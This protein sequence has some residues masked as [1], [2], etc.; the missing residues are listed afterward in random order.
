MA[1]LVHDAVQ[2]DEQDNVSSITLPFTATSGASGLVAA[3]GCRGAPETHDTVK[4][5][6]NT[7][8]FTKHVDHPYSVLRTS[9]WVLENPTIKSDNVVLT[10]G[11]SQPTVAMAVFSVS[12]LKVTDPV[13]DT[14]TDDGT[15][16][17]VSVDLTAETDDLCVDSLFKGGGAGATQGGG[18]TVLWSLTGIGP[19]GYIC[20]F[21]G[22]KEDG[23]ASVTMSW[24]FDA[25][26]H[27][28]AAMVLQHSRGGGQAIWFMIE[29]LRKFYEDLKRG[30]ISQDQ[31][32]RRYR[33]GCAI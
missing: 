10:L 9:L 20:G 11:G 3:C 8:D 7:E 25:I 4:W 30:S 29:R 2:T 6:G 16:G 17:S 33:E 1:V 18:Q 27:T 22:S 23:A 12:G 28:Y 32:E 21:F 24:S 31:I 14:G 26:S 13:G 15:G 19:V 5:N